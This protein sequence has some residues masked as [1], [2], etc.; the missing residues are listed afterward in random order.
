MED[1]LMSRSALLDYA[2]D[3]G[4][5]AAYGLVLLLGPDNIDGGW[6]AYQALL[7][8]FREGE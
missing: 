2:Q 7:E 1:K 6:D 5:E 3:C 4:L 8:M